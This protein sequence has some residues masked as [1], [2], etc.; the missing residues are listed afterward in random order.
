MNIIGIYKIES[1][2]KSYRIQIGSSLNVFN[3][4]KS[5]LSK[6]RRNKHAN[7]KLQNHFNKYG[8]ADLNFSILLGCEK[9]YLIKIEQYFLDSYKPYFNICEIA[10]N[11]LGRKHSEKTKKLLSKIGKGKTH[12]YPKIK[13]TFLPETIEKIRQ[14]NIGKKR[15][16]ETCRKIS[17]SH[18]NIPHDQLLKGRFGMKHTEETK[19]KISNAHLG[20]KRGKYK[21]IN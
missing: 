2:C 13:R 10:G 12:N 6:L 4:W 15:S 16:I 11:S 8:E 19:N 21:K 5:H 14:S 17:L 3:R 7:S 18:K 20:V 1:K 9:E